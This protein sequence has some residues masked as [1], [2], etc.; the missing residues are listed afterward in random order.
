MPLDAKCLGRV[1]AELND[2]LIGAKIDK[3][4]QPSRDEIVMAV[5]S[6]GDNLKLFVS[7]NPNSPRMHLT[8][9]VRENPTTPPMFCMLMRKHLTSGRILS[10]S[11]VPSERIVRVEMEALNEFGDR[12]KRE[13]V[14]EMMGRKANVILLDEDKRIID[15]VRRVGGDLTAQRQILPG[16]FY[17]LP[18]GKLGLSPLINRE[19]EFRDLSGTSID[20]L[21]ENEGQ[22]TVLIR[23]D[24]SIDFTFIPILQYG[25]E[26]SSKAYPSFSELLDDYYANREISQKGNQKSTELTKGV[27]RGIERVSRR[28]AL[29]QQELLE[30]QGRER[31]RELGDILTSNIYSIRKGMDKVTCADFYHPENV[32]IE[33][34]IDPLLSPQENAAKYYKAYNKAKTA[35]SILTVQ[36]LKGKGEL[37]YL[38]GVLE[39]ISLAEGERDL[40]EIRVELSQAGFLRS[41]GKQNLKQKVVTKPMEFRTTSGM[42]VSVGKNNTQNDKLTTKL[43]GK[44]DLWFHAQ[45]IHGSHVILWTEGQ[46]PDDLSFTQTA[47]LAAWFSQA[48]DGKQVPVDY[49]Y[50]RNI[51]KPAGSR[52]GMVTFKTHYTAYVDP[53]NE[54]AKTLRVK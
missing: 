52:L 49:T 12:V 46:E 30:T 3:I 40:Q 50:V 14:V 28:V 15:C 27:Q 5:R 44:D 53:D 32:E 17:R 43:A 54:L 29:Q 19:L 9:Q 33:I 51:K 6:G 20:Q 22:P 26:V 36:I 35:E 23:D 21:I 1:V 38:E 45:H 47:Q 16:M 2:R 42:R 4:H 39:S 25:P 10:I 18:E 8:N 11:Q 41:V 34:P 7:G 13:L 24:K 48:R 37:E 31:N